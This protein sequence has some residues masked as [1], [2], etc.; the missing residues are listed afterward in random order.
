MTEPAEVYV[1]SLTGR[2]RETNISRANSEVREKVKH[3]SQWIDFWAVDWNHAGD[4]FH[5]EWQAFRTKKAQKLP[6]TTATTYP[7]PGD[8]RVMVKVIDIIGNDTTKTLTVKV[9]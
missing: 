5:N 2:A 8:Y 7:E 3:W 4:T 9:K 6:L 1:T